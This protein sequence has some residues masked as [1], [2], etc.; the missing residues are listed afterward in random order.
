MAPC[1]FPLS[2][3]CAAVLPW[4]PMSDFGI[5]CHHYMLT[6]AKKQT[7][8]DATLLQSIQHSSRNYHDNC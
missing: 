5:I 8:Q 4:G 1:P 2:S 6:A 7:S 3:F